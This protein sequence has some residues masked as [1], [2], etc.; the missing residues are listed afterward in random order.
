MTELRECPWCNGTKTATHYR[1]EWAGQKMYT[2]VCMTEGCGATGPI[3]SPEPAAISAWNRRA[4]DWQSIET[5]PLDE[6]GLVWVADGGSM[7]PDG[8]RAGRIA[9]GRVSVYADLP[10]RAYANGYSGDWLITAWRPL[11]KG[12]GG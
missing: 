10:R 2:Q 4:D 9:F 11:P 12:P 7:Q 3:R 1:G 6:E 8:K 5:C